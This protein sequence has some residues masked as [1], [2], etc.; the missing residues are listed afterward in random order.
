[1]NISEIL[2]SLIREKS[3]TELFI[4]QLQEKAQII[5]FDKN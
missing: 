5:Y 1:M 3:M 4:R 2:V